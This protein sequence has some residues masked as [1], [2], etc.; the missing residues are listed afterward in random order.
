MKQGSKNQRSGAQQKL[1][2]GMVAEA[3]VSL[4]QAPKDA[5]HFVG[6]EQRRVPCV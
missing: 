1:A 4:N 5:V 3:S 2:F 6:E